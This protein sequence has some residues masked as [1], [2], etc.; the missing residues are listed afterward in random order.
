MRRCSLAPVINNNKN[1]N[2]KTEENTD[3]NNKINA[4]KLYIRRLSLANN[5]LVEPYFSMKK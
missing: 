3:N 1:N 5:D 2:N 4:K